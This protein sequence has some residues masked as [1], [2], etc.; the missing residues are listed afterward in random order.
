MGEPGPRRSFAAMTGPAYHG[1]VLPTACLHRPPVARALIPVVATLV[2]LSFAAPASSQP[3]FPATFFGTAT[4]DGENVP[5]GTPVVAWIDGVNC[6]QDDTAERGTI[7]EGGVSSYA[8]LVVHESQRPGCG[9]D[10]KLIT[11]TVG[12]REANETAE[13]GP[14]IYH[15]DLS[16]GDAGPVPLPTATPTTPADATAAAATATELARYTPLPGA[17][18]PPDDLGG[19]GTGDG[20]SSSL[21]LWLAAAVAALAAVGAAGGLLLSRRRYRPRTP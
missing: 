5:D 9:R 3:M 18:P 2:G 11:F 6:T 20:G 8:I 10:G 4:I 19:G 21:A 17:T 1:A 16:V 14:G 13:W 15:V 12:G 7:V